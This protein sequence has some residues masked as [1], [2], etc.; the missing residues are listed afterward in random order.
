M[1]IVVGWGWSGMY[2]MRGRI[3]VFCAYEQDWLRISEKVVP[4]TKKIEGV[5]DR[6]KRTYVDSG[7][8]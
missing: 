3:G 6:S 4:C 8:G 5:V 7:Y 2:G 1:R